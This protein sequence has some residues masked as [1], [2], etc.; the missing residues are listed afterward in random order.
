MTPRMTSV[1]VIAACCAGT[2]SAATLDLSWTPDQTADRP[3][4][5]LHIGTEPGRYTQVLTSDEA[6]I[7]LDG[8]TDEQVYYLRVEQLQRKDVKKGESPEALQLSREIA[9]MPA[10]R[11]DSVGSLL[12]AGEAD[13]YRFTVSG[14][15]FAPEARVRIGASSFQ[16]V[17]TARTATGQ[18]SVLVRHT[19]AFGEIGLPVIALDQVLVINPGPKTPD[20]YAARPSAAD[21]DGNGVVDAADLEALRRAFGA[22]GVSAGG[23][24]LNGDGA[25]D[26]EDLGVL[27]SRLGRS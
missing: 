13:L 21:V 1:F 25:V 15:N 20:Y 18:L 16:V 4:Y 19:P 24:D 8:L 6:R 23:A 14:A 2:A 17:E 11:I 10:P 27:G 26:G 7:H 5:R 12:P 22:S 9:L 3:L